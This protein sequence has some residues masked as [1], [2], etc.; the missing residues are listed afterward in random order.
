MPKQG[1]AKRLQEIQIQALLEACDETRYP[2]RNRVVV[3]L[4]FRAGLRRM[5]IA[6]LKRYMVM[7]SDGLIGHDIELPPGICKK[8]SKRIIPMHPQLRDA[9]ITMLK[10]VPGYPSYPLILSERAENHPDEYENPGPMT[11]ESIGYLFYRLYR[12]VQLV[13]CSSHS[14]RRTFITSAAQKV[15]Q[16]PGTSL[17]DVQRLAGHKSL[18]TTQGYID[19][20]EEARRALV[21][22]L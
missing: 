17:R 3:L 15:K 14:G 10:R 2:E 21:S 8:G 1:Q 22:L 9:I 11:A 4:S 20:D 12:R 5:E 6:G 7:D 16:V 18:N 19:S 13:G